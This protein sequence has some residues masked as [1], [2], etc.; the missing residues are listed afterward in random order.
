MA[1]VFK[2][3]DR[4]EEVSR[5]REPPHSVE[6][7]Q[8]VL[9][10][11]L[12]D[13]LACDRTGDS[14]TDSDFYRHEHR[15]IYAAIDALVTQSKP[16]DV[17]T[18][19]EQLQDLGKAQDV[20]GLA[21][22]NALAQSVPSAANVRA[23]AE[24]VQQHSRRR[25]ALARLDEAR[26]AILSTDSPGIS[27]IV[28]GLQ[29]ALAPLSN[30]PAAAF[31][32]VSVA[33]VVDTE[34]PPIAFWW[35]GFV[36]AGVVTLLGA[37]GG[38]GKSMLGLMLAAC[39]TLGVPL[40][41]VPT[42]AGRV[43]FVSAEDPAPVVLLRLR[44]ICTA[45][46]LDLR[47]V[48][49][50]LLILDAGDGDPALYRE[51][52]AE[53]GTTTPAFRWLLRRC[54]EFGADLIVLD[55]AS[56]LFDANEIVRA[57]VRAFMRALTALAQPGR[58]ILLLAHVDKNTARGLGGGEGY[59]G[60]TAWH[61]S[62]RSRLFLSRDKQG[63]LLLEQQ[64]SNLGPQSAEPLR[65]T[66][67]ADGVPQVDAAPGG[68]VGLI[69]ERNDMK[70][71]LKLLAEFTARG[72]NVGTGTTSRNHA[73]KLLRGQPGFPASLSDTE[74]FDL[75]RM[76]ERGGYISRV[77]FKGVD[78]HKRERWELTPA[79]RA[80]A[81]LAGTAGTAATS[82]LAAVAAVPASRAGT[83]ATSPLGGVGGSAPHFSGCNARLEASA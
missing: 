38:V 68:V 44:R 53:T 13:N 72:E 25:T 47:S 65:L 43:V 83:A 15:L 20:G 40:F 66:W 6:A 49:E 62:A 60:S 26:A 28:G 79:G 31:R 57:R 18:V 10:G 45:L 23:Y 4:D 56:D 46:G 51:A 37:H 58:G 70:A 11:L 17:I 64:K 3:T 7:E 14:L 61:N 48:A 67:P 24:I 1:A 80:F 22:L 41:G 71:M 78:R 36:P 32:E 8:S 74:V 5:L 27:A 50:R 69:A 42:R 30:G 34:P 77:V 52:G 75:L 76:A 21:Y 9:G 2:M 39:T 12:L 54:T 82:E 81:G 33:E 55:N 73:G 19:F 63:G 59:S 29:A 35:G 16:A